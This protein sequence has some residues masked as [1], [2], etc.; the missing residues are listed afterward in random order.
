METWFI[1][2]ASP[3]AAASGP[4]PRWRVA[5]RSPPGNLGGV[6]C[7]I[8][9]GA[10]RI[11]ASARST[12]PIGWGLFGLGAVPIRTA[13]LENGSQVLPELFEDDDVR[14]RPS[15]WRRSY[16]WPYLNTSPHRADLPPSTRYEAPAMNEAL[17]DARNVMVLKISS[18]LPTRL[19]STVAARLAFLS[20]VPVIPSERAIV[21]VPDEVFRSK[22]YREQS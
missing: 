21:A 7:C 10:R 11:E 9:G 22:H 12:T 20:A 19:S 14:I 15:A 8:E 16:R 4:K 5:I 17:S 18:G 1:T 3:V 13:F 2:G 6:G